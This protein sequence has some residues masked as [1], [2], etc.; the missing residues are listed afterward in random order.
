MARRKKSEKV[1]YLDYIPARAIEHEEDEEGRLV[2]LR[3]KFIKGLFAKILQP[4]IKTKYFRV[5]LDR[6]G[7]K[8]W[9]AIDGHRTVGEIA[10]VLFDE[11]GD[12]IEPRYERC[13]KFINS[14][15]RGAMVTL[16]LRQQG[17]S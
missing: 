16:E 12:E 14:L 6:F 17:E 15:H 7:A 8:T 10:D 11:F 1:N 2:L 13:S 9:E 4:N 3:P 5:K